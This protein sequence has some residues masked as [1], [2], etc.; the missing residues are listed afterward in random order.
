MDANVRNAI[1]AQGITGFDSFRSLKDED[2]RHLC[3]NIRRP[4]SAGARGQPPRIPNPGMSLGHVLE[5]RLKM[6]CYFV[7]HLVRVQR[8][9]DPAIATLLKLS[10]VYQLKEL[11]DPEDDIPLPQKLMH[12]DQARDTIEDIED[13]FLRK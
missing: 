5:M 6:L 12:A 8:Q 7:N 2:I 9:F 4:G 3:A 13:Y 1:I 10:E 11:D